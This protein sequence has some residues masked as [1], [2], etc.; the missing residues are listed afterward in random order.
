MSIAMI[1][2]LGAWILCGIFAVLLLGDLLRTE[3]HFKKGEES[4]QE[5]NDHDTEG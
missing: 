2:N 3:A 5:V 1:C 4:H